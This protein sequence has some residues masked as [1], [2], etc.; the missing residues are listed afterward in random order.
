MSKIKN[1]VVVILLI[2]KKI[3]KSRLDSQIM[4][5]KQI[6]I[7]FLSLDSHRIARERTRSFWCI[8]S[9]TMQFSDYRKN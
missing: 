8:L 2:V 1:G 5:F 4:Q 3:K 6:N 7:L 9:Q